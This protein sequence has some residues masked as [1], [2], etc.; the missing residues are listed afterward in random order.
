MSQVSVAESK[1]FQDFAKK[2]L[3]EADTTRLINYL[4]RNPE[5][6]DLIQGTGGLRKIRWA[7]KNEGKRGGYRI[8]YYYYN[9]SIPLYLLSGFAKN[10]M[11]NISD[12]AKAVLANLAE[13]HVKNY[14]RKR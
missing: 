13:E 8:V 14:R 9:E 4:S 3:N 6:G 10:E 7:R 12:T 2:H 1:M 11:E 5:S